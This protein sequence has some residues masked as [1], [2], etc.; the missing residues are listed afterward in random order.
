MDYLII[1]THAHLWLHQDT[2]VDGQKIKTL[3]NGKSQ[4]MGEIR[5]MLPPFLVD[6]QNTAEVLLSNMDYGQVSA[7]VITQALATL[8][9]V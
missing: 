3:E 2:M 8:G 9:W 1:D 4:F 5:Q 7:A 6:G